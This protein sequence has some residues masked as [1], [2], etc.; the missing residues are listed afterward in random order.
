MFII[1]ARNW[2]ICILCQVKK[3]K[4]K[5]IDPTKILRGHPDKG[6][7]LLSKNLIAFNNVKELPFS[8]ELEDLNGGD[9]LKASFFAPS[10]CMA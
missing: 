4:E 10:Y 2:E 5:L 1:S 3:T 8:I 7:N 6:Y 9:G